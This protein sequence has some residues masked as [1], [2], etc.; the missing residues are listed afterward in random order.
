MIE[1]VIDIQDEIE[2]LIHKNEETYKINPNRII[3]D[4]RGEKQTTNDYRGRQLLELLQ[5]ADDAKTNKIGIHLDTENKIL[6]VANNGDKF[7]LNGIQSLLIANLSSKHKKEFIGNKGLG[8]RSILNWTSEINIKTKDFTLTFSPALAKQRFLEFFPDEQDRKTVLEQNQKYLDKAEV[9]FAILALPKH[10]EGNSNQ[11]WETIIELKYHEKYEDEIV[12]QL[13]A[14]S[15]K[16]L[17]FLN[18]T[19]AIEISGIEH[20]NTRFTRH[21]LNDA[22]SEIR[23]NDS[24]WHIFDSGELKF[25]DSDEKFYQF[26]IAWQDDLSDEDSTFFTYFPTEVST[27]LPFL[28]HATFE[29]NQSRNDLLKGD[30]NQ[31]LLE[32]I[33]KAIGEIAVTRMRNMGKSDWKAFQFLEPLHA[34]SN[35]KLNA[36]FEKLLELQTELE[37]YPCVDGSYCILEE[38]VFYND[39]FSNWVRR[40]KVEQSFTDLL[41][42]LE[43]KE[44]P[45]ENFR[46][47]TYEGWLEIIHQINNKIESL[48]ERALLISLFTGY[49]FRE[50]QHSKTKLPLLLNKNGDTISEHTQVFTLTK[51]HIAQYKIPDYVDI[52]FMSGELYEKLLKVLKEEVDDK[53]NGTEDKSRPLKRVIGDVVNIGS[54]DITEVIRNIV[55][56]SD[57]EMKEA[58]GEARNDIAIGLVESLFSIYQVNPDRR[59]SINLNIT[60]LNKNL[61]LCSARDLYLGSE[62]DL[63]KTTSIIFR[64]IF[65]DKDFV[66]GNEF[67][68]LEEGGYEYLENFFGWLGVNRLSKTQTKSEYL[69][70]DQEDGYTIFVFDNVGWPDNNSHKNYTAL[71][72]LDFTKISS[73]PNFSLENLIAWVISDSKIWSQLDFD[74]SDSFSHSY[75]NKVTPVNYKPSYIYYQLKELYLNKQNTKIIVDLDFATEL[76]HN[77]IDFEHPIFKELGIDEHDIIEILDQLDISISFNDLEPEEVYDLIQDLSSVDIEGK[78]ARKLYNLAF[79]YFRTKTEV[80]F[81]QY[82]KKHKLFAKRKGK[83]EYIA[84]DEVYYS[85]N[86]T[87]PSKIAEEFWMLDFPKRMGESQ[88]SRFFGVKTFKDVEIRIQEESIKISNAY[89]D[90][91]AWFK[92][93][94]PYILT[95]RLRSINKSIEKTEADELKRAEITLVSALKYTI[96]VGEEKMLLAGEFLPKSNDKGYYLCVEKN[97]T[98]DTI[99]DTPKVCEAFAEILCTI[100]KVNDHKD[101]YRAIFKDK[102]SLKDTKYLIDVKSLNEFYKTAL[103]LLGISNEEISFWAKIYDFKELTLPNTIKDTNELNN[104]VLK[105]LGFDLSHYQTNIDYQSLDNQESVQFLKAINNELDV[106]LSTIFESNSNGLLN[107]H[108]H[109]FETIIYDHKKYFNSSL[110]SYLKKNKNK[111]KHLISFQEDY[112]YLSESQEILDKLYESR[113]LLEVDYLEILKNV[114]KRNFDFELKKD[115]TN[116]IVIQPEYV[117]LLKENN[118]SEVDIEDVEIRSLLYFEGNETVLKECLKIDEQ[119]NSTKP[120]NKPKE[121]LTGKLIFSN[122]EKVVPKSS[123]KSTGK[124]GSWNHGDKDVKRNKQAGKEAE[125]RVYNALRESDE[126]IN[127]EW[128]SSFSNTSDKSD[129]KHYDI[130]Y[131]PVNSNNWKY[132]EVKAFNGSYFHLSKSEKEEAIKRGKDFEIALVMGEEIHILR[133]YFKKEIDFDNNDLFYASPAD[134]IITLK[135]KKEK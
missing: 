74:N 46:Y 115:E 127:V 4:F 23:V 89:Q 91:Q 104:L 79:N 45:E 73:N 57:R 84:V 49:K 58:E 63:G 20:L 9:P 50:I 16:I 67:W 28:I 131:K 3:S 93:I 121:K 69:K 1:K 130:R 103:N 75:H 13:E 122:T 66:A 18:H 33:A 81:S 111:Q 11:K 42:P 78:N 25:P 110:W 30:V 35:T 80:D 44:L 8:F 105:D 129:T 86:A 108:L 77:A 76:G 96:K 120:E 52:S 10:K 118:L 128:V 85:D 107:F 102:H 68:Q 55:T 64:D 2:N 26:K 5:N 124:R 59:N 72:L 6:S 7:D 134:Y 31:F 114:V 116:I 126:V 36:F 123:K 95:Y 27:Q 37:I 22:K 51:A 43:D 98:L 119:D 71:E 90:F 117:K 101:D 132:L 94:K 100:F 39:E 40:N 21:F 34:N 62:Y 48:H 61:D 82:S 15:P 56:T 53:W 29:L 88:I 133:D 19:N 12:K 38:A 17:L 65:T 87:L 54:N 60:L 125:E 70:R 41:I 92:Q 14:I 83:K 99:K 32:E 109:N 47:Y 106:P 135:I 113:F 24:T 97:T 112:E